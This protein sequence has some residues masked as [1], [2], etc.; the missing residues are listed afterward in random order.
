MRIDREGRQ[1]LP[2][3]TDWWRRNDSSAFVT[4]TSSPLDLQKIEQRVD[5]FAYNGVDDFIADVQLML[6]NVVQYCNSSYEVFFSLIVSCYFYVF[7]NV[8][9]FIKGM[10][11]KYLP[12][13]SSWFSI[14]S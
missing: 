13:I 11:L 5:G 14:G 9:V 7:R 6:S 1:L 8:I 3:L 2:V 12:T 4:S 10:N